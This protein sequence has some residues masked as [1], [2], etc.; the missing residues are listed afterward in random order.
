MVSGVVLMFLRMSLE[1][2]LRVCYVGYACLD[3]R[4]LR[5]SS[6]SCESS[7][8]AVAEHEYGSKSAWPSDG[9]DHDLAKFL[10]D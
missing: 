3:V 1:R 9:E 2:R 7:L 5:L 6:D 8:M 10:R 4:C